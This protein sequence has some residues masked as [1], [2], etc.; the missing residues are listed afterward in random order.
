VILVD[1]DVLIDFLED[2]APKSVRDAAKRGGLSTTAIAAYEVRRGARTDEARDSVEVLLQQM[3]TIETFDDAAAMESAALYRGLSRSGQLIGKADLYIA[4]ICLAS[5][6]Q[7]LTR[8]VRE[9]G[10]VP[11]LQ[12]VEP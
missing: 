4:G 10:R 11:G 3:S 12:L 7:L 2:C 8:N 9:Y 5:G 6:A 1:T